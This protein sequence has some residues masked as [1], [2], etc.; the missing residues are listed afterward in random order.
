MLQFDIGKLYE[1]SWE[2]SDFQ[3]YWSTT[4]SNLYEYTV[5]R[6][7][8]LHPKNYSTAYAVIRYRKTVW[9]VMRKFRCADIL[10]HKTSCLLSATHKHTLITSKD[11]AVNSVWFTASIT[12]IHELKIKVLFPIT[13]TEEIRSLF[14][15]PYREPGPLQ[16][17]LIL[18]SG[19]QS[20]LHLCLSQRVLSASLFSLGRDDCCRIKL[21]THKVSALLWGRQ[22]HFCSLY[23][24]RLTSITATIN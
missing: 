17:R 5:I 12:L 22:T 11:A 2:N 18:Q 14:N 8:S 24:L 4:K 10:T 15:S 23:L 21:D 6:G 7:L 3:T 20:H 16:R 19:E 1:K 13:A 9:K